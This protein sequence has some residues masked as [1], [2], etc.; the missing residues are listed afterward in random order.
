MSISSA[1]EL[2]GMQKI[3]EAVAITLKQMREHA[4]PGM[5]AE[6]LDE[7]GGKILSEMGAKSA[8]A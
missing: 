7:F 1:A 5:T 3:S 2:S 8:P 6:E 4:K